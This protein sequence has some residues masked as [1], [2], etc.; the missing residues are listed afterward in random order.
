M[1][2]QRA[3]PSGEL[4]T[5]AYSKAVQWKKERTYRSANADVVWEFVGP[6][7]IGGRITDIEIPI[8]KRC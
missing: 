5:D 7:N 3:Y 1:F 4:K 8:D 6:I 2:M